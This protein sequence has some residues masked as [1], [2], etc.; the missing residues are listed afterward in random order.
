MRTAS[1]RT[2]S[3]TTPSLS[4]R[5]ARST[6]RRLAASPSAVKAGLDLSLSKSRLWLHESGTYVKI[7]EAGAEL[8]S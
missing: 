6:T 8:F 3:V 2:I 7:T 5:P 1:S 4:L